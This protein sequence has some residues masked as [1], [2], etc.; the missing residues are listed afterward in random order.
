[1]FCLLFY[2]GY[3]RMDLTIN[4]DESVQPVPFRVDPGTA[5]AG[6]VQ[7]ARVSL[8]L[9]KQYFLVSQSMSWS[10]IGRCTVLNV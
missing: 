3:C 9:V 8:G 2:Q 6:A 4:G 1:M 10:T 5:P 7:I